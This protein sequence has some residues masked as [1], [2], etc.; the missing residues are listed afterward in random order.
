MSW[1]PSGDMVLQS[2]PLSEMLDE[3]ALALSPGQ[4]QIRGVT[5]GEVSIMERLVWLLLWGGWIAGGKSRCRE[6]CHDTV[7]WSR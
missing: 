1:K 4:W 5:S 6:T 2:D 7:Q 3:S